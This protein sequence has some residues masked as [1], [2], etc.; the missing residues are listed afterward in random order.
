M[1]RII[2][3]LKF[4][5]VYIFP[6]N[7]AFLTLI[8]FYRKLVYILCFVNSSIFLGVKLVKFY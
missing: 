8:P 7:Y 3:N 4:K 5:M 2:I 6:Y 1:L